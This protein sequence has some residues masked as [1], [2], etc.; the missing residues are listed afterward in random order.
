M[1]TSTLSI[2]Q[3]W[4]HIHQKPEALSVVIPSALTAVSN[5]PAAS[6][7]TLE[8]QKRR[9]AWS[10]DESGTTISKVQQR[11]R[12]NHAQLK[13]TI[14]VNYYIKLKCLFATQ[15]VQMLY[16]IMSHSGQRLSFFS[17]V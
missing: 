12:G 8:R 2:I 4:Q 9:R 7:T 15:D 5:M 3:L 13:M 14:T 1:I 16:T 6:E 10:T 17:I 11:A